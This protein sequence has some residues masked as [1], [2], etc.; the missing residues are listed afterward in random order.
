MRILFGAAA[1]AVLAAGAALADFPTKSIAGVIQWGAGGSTDVVMRAI[2][3]HAEKVLG[4]SIV[5]TNRTG[6]VGVI[7]TRFVQSQPSDGHTLLM[8]AENPQLY[9]VMGLADTD[10]SDFTPINV[11]A[12]GVPILVANNDAPF[13]TIPELVAYAQANPGQVRMGSTGPGGL[14]SVVGAMLQSVV[15]LPVTPVPFDGDGPALTAMQGGVVEFMP[16]VLGAAIE[17][18]KAG[19][20][21]ALGVVDTAENDAL[22]GVAPITADFPEFEKYL[23]W[24][25]FFGV[26]VKNDTP[27]DVVATLVEAFAAG[28]EAEDFKALIDGRGFQ[29]L[30]LSGAEAEEYLDRWRSVTSWLAW[31]GGLAKT[32]PEEF[33]IPQP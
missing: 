14:P 25:P 12:R 22:P 20:I 30:N 31:E 7:A 26:F 33:G 18:I 5:M 17:H 15:E 27:D 21:K 29:M 1:A 9:K 6:G 24:G 10:Y 4:E 32:S 23:P 3:P 11:I 28:A 8:G 19:R 16:A 2:A 13:D